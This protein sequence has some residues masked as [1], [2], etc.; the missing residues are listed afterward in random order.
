MQEYQYKGL[1]DCDSVCGLEIKGNVAICTELPHN[2]GTS[3]TNYAE[4]LANMVCRDFGIDPAKLVWIE[5]Y[6]Q[7]S[8]HPETFDKVTFDLN[9][10]VFSKPSWRRL[11]QEELNT[12][13]G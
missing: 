6:P 5:R 1:W 13:V 12:L 2:N 3:V 11:G 7:S 10:G 4:H 9:N 8:V